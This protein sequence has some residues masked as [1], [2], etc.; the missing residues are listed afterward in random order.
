MH[1]F[2]SYFKNIFKPCLPSLTNI[3]T[4]LP[5]YECTPKK[6]K[7]NTTFASWK[8]VLWAKKLVAWVN[9]R[10]VIWN[11]PFCYRAHKKKVIVWT[12][13]LLCC[14]GLVSFNNH[15]PYT[16]IPISWANCKPAI[17]VNSGAKGSVTCSLLHIIDAIGSPASFLITTPILDL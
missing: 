3:E 7:K 5:G 8:W 6:K 9:E 2:L 13:Q 1:W 15:P 17:A 4:T 11:Y 14:I 12:T 16:V 10:F